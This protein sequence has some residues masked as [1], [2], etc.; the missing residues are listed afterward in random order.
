MAGSLAEQLGRLPPA[1]AVGW[2]LNA[3]HGIPALPPPGPADRPGRGRRR[4]LVLLCGEPEPARRHLAEPGLD[5][6]GF[7][8]E[9]DLILDS[10]RRLRD[11]T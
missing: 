11:R 4:P 9:L 3:W 7:E 10:L 1:E 2:F 6:G 8:F 5:V